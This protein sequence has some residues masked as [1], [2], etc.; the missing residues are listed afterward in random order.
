MTLEQFLEALEKTPR[1]WRHRADGRIRRRWAFTAQ[2]PITALC[3]TRATQ[4][5]IAA[6]SL[7]ICGSL[8]DDIVAAADNDEDG[9]NF[10]LR[11][12]LLKACGL[13]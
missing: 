12:K 8:M 3:N 5:D 7:G 6:E 2:C 4:W 13:A 1:D 11:D 10:E 9:Y